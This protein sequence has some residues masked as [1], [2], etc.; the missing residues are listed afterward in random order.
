MLIVRFRAFL[1]RPQHVVVAV[2]VVAVAVPVVERRRR[3]LLLL[4][5]VT[6]A[7]TAM[8]RQ[9][10]ARTTITH[11]SVR[12][13]VFFSYAFASSCRLLCIQCLLA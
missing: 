5:L 10:P 1:F 3:L 9:V 11:Q 12:D 7:T 13:C 2:L 4:V 6:T 8:A